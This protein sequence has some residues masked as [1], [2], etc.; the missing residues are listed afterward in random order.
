MDNNFEYDDKT[1]KA[2]NDI[3]NDYRSEKIKELPYK[4]ALESCEILSKYVGQTPHIEKHDEFCQLKNV[5][6]RNMGTS[7][8]FDD[9]FIMQYSVYVDEESLLNNEFVAIYNIYAYRSWY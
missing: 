2:I 9:K 5:I 1:Q 6:V 4:D 8:I 3:L 7:K